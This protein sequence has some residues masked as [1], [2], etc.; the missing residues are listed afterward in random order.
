MNAQEQILEKI[1][2]LPPDKV[3]EVVDFID[4]MAARNRAANR[5]EQFARIHAYALEFGGTEYDLD[6]QLEQAGI[7]SLLTIDEAT[8]ATQ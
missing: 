3:A 1:N 8:D 4:F 6:P 2:S 7:E 5:D